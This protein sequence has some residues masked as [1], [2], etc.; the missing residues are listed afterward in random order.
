MDR[1]LDDVGAALSD[2]AA[3]GRES[4]H[5]RV[6]MTR[7]IGFA[8]PDHAGGSFRLSEALRERTVVLLFYRGDW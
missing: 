4:A 1:S 7:P 3:P 2:P 5:H 6:T 8:L